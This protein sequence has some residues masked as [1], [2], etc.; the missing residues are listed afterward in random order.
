MSQAA[1]TEAASAEDYAAGRML[2]EEYA[3]A[4]AVD[5]CFQDFSQEMADLPGVYGPPRGCLL[6]ARINGEWVGCVAV[7]KQDTESCEMKRLYVKTQ[8]RGLGLGRRLAEL[9]IRAAQGKDFAPTQRLL[10]VLQRPFDE[11]PGAEDLAALPP[12]WAAG[13]SVSCSS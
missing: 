6:L 8:Y 2:I 3:A 12:D 13:I 4:L 1:I 9:A 7:R 11:Q 5:L 10:D